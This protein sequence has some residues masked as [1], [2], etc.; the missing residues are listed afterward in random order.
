MID[1]PYES[2][3][4]QIIAFYGD[5]DLS[6]CSPRL[7]AL[8]ERDPFFPQIVLSI[9]QALRMFPDELVAA[10]TV[11]VPALDLHHDVLPVLEVQPEIQRL[12]PLRIDALPS[13][14]CSLIHL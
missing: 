2:C 3:V 6:L 11:P 10:H 12:V 5:E 13:N 1:T 4:P 14:P 8:K 7:I 9:F